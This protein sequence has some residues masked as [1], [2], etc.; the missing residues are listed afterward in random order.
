M[1]ACRCGTGTPSPPSSKRRSSGSWVTASRWRSHLE[2]LEVH[3]LDGTDVDGV[4]QRASRCTEQH[5]SAAARSSTD[6]H[7]VRVRRTRPGS[8]STTTV[9]S[10]RTHRRDVHATSMR[11]K[12]RCD[13]S[14]ADRP[15]RRPCRAAA[16]LSCAAPIG[17]QRSCERCT[18]SDLSCAGQSPRCTRSRRSWRSCASSDSVAIGRASRR[19]RPIGSPVSSQ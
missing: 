15:R 17:C 14:T 13:R 5:R 10:T 3:A 11:S 1:A 12:A 8:W 4:E 18:S 9:W 2:P 7:D 16:R 19:F 6:I